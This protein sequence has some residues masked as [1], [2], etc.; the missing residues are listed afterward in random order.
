L[1]TQLITLTSD[2]G[3]ND[4]SVM[5]LKSSISKQL[6]DVVFTDFSHHIKAFQI[7]HAAYLVSNLYNQFDEGTIH[8]IFVNVLARKSYELKAAK[9]KEHY[10]IG[11]DN[12]IFSYLF[13]NENVEVVSF[14]KIHESQFFFKHIA[15]SIASLIDLK[16]TWNNAP[17]TDYLKLLEQPFKITDESITG[18]IWMVD[19]FG[20]LITN[21]HR[22]QIEHIIENKSISI[23]YGY[24]TLLTT[25]EA[26]L[27]DA[28][29]FD[30]VAYYN[31]FGYLEI[32][33]RN[34]NISKLFNLN[35]G[36]TIKITYQ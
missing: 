5:L 32:A 8:C 23:S 27:F 19:D 24:K 2:F 4:G 33:I 29:P 22:N 21:I 14:G 17:K 1:Q 31:Q 28:K 11:I 26:N 13:K 18:W 9:F 25:I 35:E 16:K 7:S 36:G 30:P 10:F 6:S 20:N 15:N 34:H 12:G 3:T